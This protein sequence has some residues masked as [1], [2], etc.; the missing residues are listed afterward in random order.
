MKKIF[1]LTVAFLLFLAAANAQLTHTANGTI[2]VNATNII[3]KASAKMSGTVSFTVTVVNYDA[4]KKETFRQKADVLYNAPRYRVKAGTLEIYCDGKSVWQ[5]NKSAKE[6]VVSPIADSDD[7]LTNPA[8][9]LANY[10]KNY[11]AKFIREEKDGTA[12]IDLQPN[13]G[14]SYHKVRID[15][16]KNG[17]LKKLEQHNY[18]SSRSEYTV[19]N[20]KNA[21]ASDG[22]F[23]FDSAANSSYELI[24]M[25]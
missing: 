2:D 13:Q 12:I 23:T 18:D 1:A 20:F 22:D 19:S 5:V 6:V 21:T 3:K 14:R 10:S 8:R 17:Q 9:L 24:D 25:R 11:R 15:I 16:D 4:N 7:D